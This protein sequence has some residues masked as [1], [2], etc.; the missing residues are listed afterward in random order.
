MEVYLNSIEMGMACM[1]LK[2]RLNIGIERCQRF[3]TIQAA[4]YGDFTQSQ[5]VRYNQ[6]VIH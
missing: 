6:F 5:K 3:D 4:E 2:Q 1:A